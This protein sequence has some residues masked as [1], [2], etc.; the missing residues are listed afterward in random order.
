M[1]I[2]I[3]RYREPV[4]IWRIDEVREDGASR[5]QQY[6]LEKMIHADVKSLSWS[7]QLLGRKEYNEKPIS[8]ECNYLSDLNGATPEISSHYQLR[9]TR[10]G[11]EY[12]YSIESVLDAVDE[13]SAIPYMITKFIGSLINTGTLNNSQA[14]GIGSMAVGSTFIVS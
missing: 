3:G 2:R 13:S 12:W 9:R 4:E 10:N 11:I 6:T 1:A 8:V 14:G 7:V 5:V